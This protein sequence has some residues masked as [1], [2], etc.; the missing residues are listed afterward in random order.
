MRTLAFV[1]TDVATLDRAHA[2]S[3]RFVIDFKKG[4]DVVEI[5]IDGKKVV[6]GTTWEDYYRSDPEQAGERQRR[7]AR[8]DAALPRER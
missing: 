6:T 5:F 3:I 7:A 1:K 8:E 4:P 2:H